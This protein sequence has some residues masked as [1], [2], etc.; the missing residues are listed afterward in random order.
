MKILPA[1]GIW[2]EVA[3]REAAAGDFQSIIDLLREALRPI[4]GDMWGNI[5]AVFPDAVVT[6]KGARLYRYPY[7]MGE[8]N[9]V[10]LGQP[11]EVVRNFGPAGSV[12]VTEAQAI[13]EA[14]GGD[15]AKP[16]KGWRIRVIKAGLSGNGVFYPDAVLREAAPMFN[17]A[18]VFNK[19]DED[20]LKARGK[21]F[22]NLIGRLTEAQFVPGKGKDQGEILAVLDLIEPTGGIA[23]KLREAWDRGM[24]DLFGFSI[25]ANA[26]AVK[27]QVGSQRILEAQ[28]VTKVHS[29]DLIIDPGA[30]GEVVQ[31]L[32]AKATTTT[33]GDIMDRDAIIKLLEARHPRADLVKLSDEELQLRLAEALNPPSPAPTKKTGDDQVV[34][35]ADLRLVE[36]R[37]EARTRVAASKLPQA[38]KDRVLAGLLAD[39]QLTDARIT[40]AIKAEADYLGQFATGGR[41]ELGDLP[42]ARI[43]EGQDEKVKDR[44]DAFFDPAHK[45]HRAAGSFRDIYVDISGDAR[46]TGDM[47]KGDPVR[48]REALGSASWANVLGNSITRRLLADYR[49]P[50][51][52]DVWRRIAHIVPVADFRTQERTRIGGYGDL[53]AVNQ[54]A[55]YTALT[56]PGD[57]KATYAASKRG[58]LET[59]TLEM[60][61]NDDVGAIRQ[62]PVK[63]SRA[64][65][66]TLAKFVLDFI[67]GNP[68]IYDGKALF[69]ADHGN[70]GYA[71]LSAG[72]VAA[73]RLAML[74]QPELGS[75]ERLGIGPKSILVSSEQ[76]GPAVD[77]W[78]RS[79]NNDKTFVQSLVLDV[80]PI[81]YWTDPSDWAMAADPLDIP[82]LEVGFLDGQEEPEIF[83][84][85][86]PNVGSMFVADKLTY[87]IRH[88]YGG[89]ITD[90]RAFYKSVVAD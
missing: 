23:V 82:G 13:R 40:E 83:V 30:G 80:L 49:Q 15:Q 53:P 32:E 2:G 88:I 16:A 58:G 11:E 25:D 84:Q 33:T 7:T 68:V 70:L 50:S 41:V 14:V 47:S 44:L 22:D 78:A 73:G 64:T 55:D 20:H 4:V 9:Q 26:R 48:L 65:K 63:L 38:A 27:R 72:A 8:D 31:L 77:L 85:D 17:G 76:E 61:K 75:G 79:T 34:T 12:R 51:Q 56:S 74:N 35:L 60:V 29:V 52:Y 28:R 69:H 71:A 19:S 46:V 1:S 42:E 89:N 62:V 6:Q 87:K 54:S 90:W 36:A 86:M 39:E 3:L 5:V 81:W 10:T 67:R 43:T 59:I 37:A 21:S 66:R 45:D 24:A 18:R 57:E